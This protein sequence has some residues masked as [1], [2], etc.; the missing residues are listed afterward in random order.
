LKAAIATLTAQLAALAPAIEAGRA[1]SYNAA[2]RA[3]EIQDALRALD[4][5]L[6][7]TSM[8]LKEH[9]TEVRKEVNKAKAWLKDWKSWVGIFGGV[10][11]G[12]AMK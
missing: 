5:Q 10:V 6:K 2:I 3:L 1:E 4:V 8:S 9:R 11:G 12:L 7:A